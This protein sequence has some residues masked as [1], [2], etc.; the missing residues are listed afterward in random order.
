MWVNHRNFPSLVDRWVDWTQHSDENENSAQ[1][2]VN[3]NI[4][5]AV[6]L[7]FSP[8]LLLPLSLLFVPALLPHWGLFWTWKS[9]IPEGLCGPDALYVSQIDMH[10]N[11]HMHKKTYKLPPTCP[12]APHSYTLLHAHSLLLWLLQSTSAWRKLLTTLPAPEQLDIVVIQT[13]WPDSVVF[14]FS[15]FVFFQLVWITIRSVGCCRKV[16]SSFLPRELS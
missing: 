2:S 5:C 6:L 9:H 1:I 11:T 7:P 16:P 12:H 4:V 15:F 10:T 3:M 8:L 13:P 14:I